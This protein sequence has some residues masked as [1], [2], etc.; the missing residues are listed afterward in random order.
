MITPFIKIILRFIPTLSGLAGLG[1]ILYSYLLETRLPFEIC[2][3]F[4]EKQINFLILIL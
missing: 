4:S 3:P 2:F 1:F